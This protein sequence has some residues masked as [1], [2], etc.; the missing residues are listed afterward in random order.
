MGL[1]SPCD[2]HAFTELPL[3]LLVFAMILKLRYPEVSSIKGL[4]GALRTDKEKK[5]WQL[6]LVEE[7]VHK[8]M[9]H[10][11]IPL[12]P[13]IS[14]GLIQLYTARGLMVHAS[15]ALLRMPRIDS[16]AVTI[17]LHGCVIHKDMKSASTI[18]RNLGEANV[19]YTIS[20]DLED[21]LRTAGVAFGTNVTIVKKAVEWSWVLYNGT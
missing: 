10:Y 4:L 18:M 7:K 9:R 14:T 16:V 12:D 6:E 19:T 20:E 5:Q 13:M 11:E 21:K 15:K 8:L 2:A 1:P 17:F 3:P